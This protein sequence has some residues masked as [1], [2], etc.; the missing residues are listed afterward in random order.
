[1]DD[2]GYNVEEPSRHPHIYAHGVVE[3]EVE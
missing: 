1:M 2:A 3:V